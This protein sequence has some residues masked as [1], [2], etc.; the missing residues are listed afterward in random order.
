MAVRLFC[1]F[2]VGSVSAA[3]YAGPVTP[4]E[5]M[6]AGTPQQWQTVSQV[7]QA[8]KASLR[9]RWLLKM[10]DAATVD[11]SKTIAATLATE[12]FRGWANSKERALSVVFPVVFYRHEARAVQKTRD[13]FKG[14]IPTRAR[15]D[16]RIGEYYALAQ[17]YK[18]SVP[19][20]GLPEPEI[21]RERELEVAA[22]LLFELLEPKAARLASTTVASSAG[23]A[24]SMGTIPSSMGTIHPIHGAPPTGTII[25]S[26]TASIPVALASAHGAEG[27]STATQGVPSASPG[28]LELEDGPPAHSAGESASLGPATSASGLRSTDDLASAHQRHHDPSSDIVLREGLPDGTEFRLR[29]PQSACSDFMCPHCGGTGKSQ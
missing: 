3:L 20:F 9:E 1:G 6:L 13:V 28:V 23:L 8:E 25:P 5:F 2:L 15:L 16:V 24:P 26:P 18:A 29:F 14:K 12:P 17:E 19:C 21:F 10:E 27:V 4:F 22:A 7:T 11:T